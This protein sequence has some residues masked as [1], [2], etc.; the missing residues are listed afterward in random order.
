MN[1][2]RTELL[3]WA[4]EYVQAN[5]GS[6]YLGAPGGFGATVS[7]GASGVMTVEIN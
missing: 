2:T 1:M 5:S 4:A 6:L 7:M 3:T